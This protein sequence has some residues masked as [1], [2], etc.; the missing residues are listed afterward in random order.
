MFSPGETSYFVEASFIFSSS[1]FLVRVL[2]PVVLFLFHSTEMIP[3]S[4]A[5]LHLRMKGLELEPSSALW[6][7]RLFF[8]GC[9]C[10]GILYLDGISADLVRLYDEH[11]CIPHHFILH[12]SWVP[13][14]WTR[15]FAFLIN[16]FKIIFL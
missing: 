9:I 16:S 8:L 12:F 7:S 1:S 13:A 5:G 10:E 3:R 14:S 11:Q 2:G 6:S 4:C 15:C